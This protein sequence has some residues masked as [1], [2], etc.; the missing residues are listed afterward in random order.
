MDM[1]NLVLVVAIPTLLLSTLPNTIVLIT[2]CR[3]RSVYFASLGWSCYNY[4]QFQKAVHTYKCAGGHSS[5]FS[6]HLC[7]PCRFVLFQFYSMIRSKSTTY[8]VQKKDAWIPRN[9]IFL[10]WAK[11]FSLNV[12]LKILKLI[13]ISKS[14]IRKNSFQYWQWS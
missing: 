2:I 6:D 4:F 9:M 10:S 13:Y 3:T 1:L 7:S 11:V 12:Y 5:N 8:C 14:N